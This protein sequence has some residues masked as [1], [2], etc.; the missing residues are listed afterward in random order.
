MY[1]KAYSSRRTKA[2]LSCLTFGLFLSLLLGCKEEKIKYQRGDMAS[3][4][5]Q[6]KKSNKKVFVLVS[7]NA[8]GKCSV[9]ENFLNTQSITVDILKKDYICYKADIRIPAEHRIAE[10]LKNPSYPFPYFFDQDGKLLAFG[11]P[12]S[13]E[14]NI[15][16]L[17]KITIDEKKFA[18]MFKMDI[19]VKQYKT[20][21]SNVIS[22]TQ[23]FDSHTKSDS[24]KAFEMLNIS[25][26]MAKYPYNV[27]SANLLKRESGI[28]LDTNLIIENY[29]V[30]GP[31]KFL[32][33][34]VW[35]YMGLSKPSNSRNLSSLK[36]DYEILETNKVMNGLTKGKSYPFKF[37]IKNISK[38]ELRLL[39]I[40]HPCDCIKL[41][42]DRSPLA[43]GKVTMVEGQF[44]PYSSGS[45]VKE[46]FIHSN[47]KTKPMGVYKLLGTVD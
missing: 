23:L 42:W 39:E 47:S 44:T 17:S 20:L 1:L 6:A 18:E 27:R 25:L 26:S 19:G 3:I 12:N 8:C 13:P 37:R 29:K 31:D 40:S 7:D 4:F 21:I 28:Q 22:Y 43:E 38:S 15:E 2:L 10:L 46:I 34:D 30:S 36:Q 5:K 32:Y 35:K 14:Y 9:F 41:E 11:F 24:L 33:G 45:F 16:D